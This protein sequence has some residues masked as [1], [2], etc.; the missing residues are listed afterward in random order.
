MRKK[1]FITIIALITFT[2]CSNDETLERDYPIIKMLSLSE[3]G[4]NEITI[5]AKIENINNLKIIEHGYT[6]SNSH[7]DIPQPIALNGE[8][9]SGVFSTDI[10]LPFT[11]NATYYYVRAY[12]KTDN[13][14]IFSNELSF[15]TFP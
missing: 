13:L 10:T 8:V 7:I 6:L 12:I 14:T 11:L 3:K 9:N 4:R 5:T 1:L 15:I 2:Q